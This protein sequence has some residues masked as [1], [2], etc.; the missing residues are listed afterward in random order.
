AVNT[1][2]ISDPANPESTPREQRYPQAGSTNAAV[3]LHYFD[4]S[5]IKFE[6]DWDHDAYEYLISLNWQS[7]SDPLITVANRAQTEFITHAMREQELVSVHAITDPEFVEVIPG[8]PRWLGNEIL[9]VIDNRETDTR[10]LRVADRTLTPAGLQVMSVISASEDFI[11]VIATDDAVSRKVM[12]VLPSGEI[13]EL[14]KDGVSSAT[15]STAVG[16]DSWQIITQSRLATHSRTYTLHRNDEQIHQFDSHAEQPIVTPN[17]Q[18]FETGPH[19]VKTAV[20]F[21]ESHVPGSKKLPIMLRPYGGPHGAQVLDA[22]NLYAEDQWFA[23]QGFCVIVA[24]NRGTPARGP[25]WDHAIYQDFVTPVL[26]DQESAIADIAK[27]F[28]N[29][30]D[31]DRVGITGWS[32]GGYLSALA[33]LA[34]PE[35]FHA[36]VAGAP[37]TDWILYDT[38][39]T[40]RYLGHPAQFP[41]VYQ[42]NSLLEMTANLQRPLLLIHGTADDN[43]V[44]AHTLQ[45]SS[46]LLAN[47]GEHNVLPLS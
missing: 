5:G 10:E 28:P 12:R 23:D 13:T 16:E 47:K 4:L 45:L 20:L 21:P 36:A 1:W 26:D 14:T 9:S 25:I 19:R 33:V 17:V 31:T 46:H 40:E 34:R 18:V 44:F 11:D 29:D 2:W 30:V 38:A 3:S 27:Q 15:S 22:A 41:E 32:F 37:V 35:V 24:D 39:Y 8:Q 42:R 7:D 43:V 6:I